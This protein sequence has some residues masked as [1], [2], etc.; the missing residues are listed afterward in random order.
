MRANHAREVAEDF[1]VCCPLSVG[2][3]GEG[4][5]W[6]T[7]ILGSKAQI[8]S[9]IKAHLRADHSEKDYKD[10]KEAHADETRDQG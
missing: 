7:H 4:C 9:R 2:D 1:D 5:D 10:W 6:T 3:I 8:F